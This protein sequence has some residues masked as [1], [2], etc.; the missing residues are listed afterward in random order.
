MGKVLRHLGRH[1]FL[2]LINKDTDCLAIK[3]AATENITEIFLEIA[4]IFYWEIPGFHRIK[5]LPRLIFFQNI[6]RA[7]KI[8]LL[9]KRKS[10]QQLRFS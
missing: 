10:L 7:V 6:V 5:I 8:G 1:F 9:W 3:Y 2:I 4:F